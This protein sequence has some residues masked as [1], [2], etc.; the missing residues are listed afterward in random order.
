MTN[1][2]EWMEKVDWG[3]VTPEKVSRII[4]LIKKIIE[5]TDSDEQEEFRYYLWDSYAHQGG[6]YKETA[7]TLSI[8]LTLLR[9]EM[10][11]SKEWILRTINGIT[12][13]H[14]NETKLSQKI[15]E[16]IKENKDLFFEYLK[17]DNYKYRWL[18][19]EIIGKLIHDED[20]VFAWIGNHLETE[21]NVSVI[22]RGIYVIGRIGEATKD[23]NVKRKIYNYLKNYETLNLFIR[24][25][26]IYSRMTLNHKY[27]SQQDWMRLFYFFSVVTDVD[28]N[29]EHFIIRLF[30]VIDKFSPN[31]KV[32]KYVGFLKCT[33]S[34]FLCQIIIHNMLWG[35]FAREN[36]ILG[37]KSK[38]EKE[39]LLALLGC[40]PFWLEGDTSFLAD[41]G[42]PT[43]KVSLSE[44]I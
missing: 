32:E 1:D 22:T 20:N 2:Y 19:L 29:I 24:C 7:P 42:L 44:K 33:K 9:Q 43:D 13:V 27:I 36:D 40:E 16:M 38:N 4:S 14:G 17:N 6:I 34:P 28:H 41:F 18:S 3:S 5:T 25:V 31:E 11:Y 26:A 30:I 37:K 39:L 21:S 8:L 10:L 12:I 23:V 15:Y 35:F